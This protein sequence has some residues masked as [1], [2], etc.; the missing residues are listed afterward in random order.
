MLVIDGDTSLL[1]P[2]VD[3]DMTV[4]GDNHLILSKMFSCLSFLNV[5]D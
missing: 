3:N 4:T 1:R 2:V 5:L